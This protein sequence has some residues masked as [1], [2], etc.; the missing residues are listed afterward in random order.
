VLVDLEDLWLEPCQQNHP[1]TGPEAGNFTRRAART[2]AEISADTELGS[3]FD[4]LTAARPGA[5]T[6]TSAA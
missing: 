2:L 1:G 5:V 6:E 4:R 3:L